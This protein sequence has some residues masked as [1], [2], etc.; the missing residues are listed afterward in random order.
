MEDQ[1]QAG[2]LGLV[3]A[4]YLGEQAGAE[5]RDGGADRDAFAE[6]AEGQELGQLCRAC[7]ALADVLGP[8]R[9][10]VVALTG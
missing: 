4:E 3:Q 8:G 10:S 6:A 7:P 5:R 9:D 1:A 2:L